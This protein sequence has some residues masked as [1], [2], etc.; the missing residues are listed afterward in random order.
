M[1]GVYR[2][3]REA[4]AADRLSVLQFTHMAWR[5]LEDTP[6]FLL[7][8]CVRERQR[9]SLLRRDLLD[10]N[11]VPG[12]KQYKQNSSNACK[13]YNIHCLCIWA[14]LQTLS[15]TVRK[16]EMQVLSLPGLN[17]H[18]TLYTQYCSSC[19]LEYVSLEDVVSQFHGLLPVQLALLSGEH[20]CQESMATPVH[21]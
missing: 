2:F 20:E 5:T 13:W 7:R 11:C 9:I 18:N 15:F 1:L 3:L 19:Y 17:L 4:S 12:V 6:V 16:L 21:M 10:L 8:P 14:M